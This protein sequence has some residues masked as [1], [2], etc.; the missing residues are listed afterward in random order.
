MSKDEDRPS[1][2]VNAEERS[3]LD[4]VIHFAPL[5]SVF[6]KALELLLKILR[7]IR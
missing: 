6:L 5:L 7:I 1:T 3:P 4:Q 2:E